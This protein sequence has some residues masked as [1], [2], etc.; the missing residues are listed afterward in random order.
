MKPSKMV[1]YGIELINCY[2]VVFYSNFLFFYMKTRFGFGE[3]ENL[4]LAALNG[5][6]YIFAAWQGGAFAQRFGYVDR[7][8]SV[9][10]ALRFR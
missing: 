10:P 9:L 7:C 6:I 2:A 1:F 5:F 4:L 8:M 3:L